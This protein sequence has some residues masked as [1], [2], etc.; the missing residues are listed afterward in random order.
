MKEI[1]LI[2]DPINNHGGSENFI[3]Y[4]NNY[5]QKFKKT[6]FIELVNTKTKEVNQLRVIK[7]FGLYFFFPSINNY[8]KIFRLMNKDMVINNMRFF[9]IIFLLKVFFK[10][11]IYYISHGFFFHNKNN[12]FF[13]NILMILH[14]LISNILEKNFKYISI[15]SND[16]KICKKF[17]LSY[18]FLE[19]K[20]DLSKF[21]NINK[22]KDN[23]IALYFGRID[24]N[25][26][27]EFAIK[28][29]FKSKNISKFIICG[30]IFDKNYYQRLINI[31]NSYKNQKI[32]FSGEL[33]HK[34]LIGHIEN[35]QYILLP[36]TEEGFG[37]TL[38]ESL[39]VNKI[40][41]A[42]NNFSY[43]R[44]CQNLK[45]YNI[46]FNYND[47]NLNIDEK[48]NSLKNFTIDTEI[49]FSKYSKYDLEKLKL[50]FV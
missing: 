23:G 22:K 14:S 26:G 5:L 20:V 35:C 24:K 42:N 12:L 50:I 32:F 47:L 13:K 17:N 7:L 21:R 38:I 6:N 25:K 31:I 46:L 8:I 48:L 33:S 28:H 43:S 29:V 36:S 37:I 19:E 3:K 18:T 40:V 9:P 30:K 16:I 4:L 10:N 34:D 2:T 49:I 11:K 44:I 1:F 15:S 39:I 41:L 45:L 27:L